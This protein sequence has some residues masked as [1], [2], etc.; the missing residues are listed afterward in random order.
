MENHNDYKKVIT[1]M[2]QKQIAVLG[3]D[4]ALLKAR[5]IE[6]LEVNDKGEVLGFKGSPREILQ[7]L[8]DEYISLSGQIFK[9]VIAPLLQKY[10]DMVVN[11]VQ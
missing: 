1:E 8:I 4:I 2:I 10:P 5:G 11:T 6:G 3:P 9:S 7:K